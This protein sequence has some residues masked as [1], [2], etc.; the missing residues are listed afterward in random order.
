M[1][2][3]NHSLSKKIAK[4][5]STHLGASIE[6]KS[7]AVSFYSLFLSFL[8]GNFFFSSFI[9]LTLLKWWM[10]VHLAFSYWLSREWVDHVL[11]EN[12]SNVWIK[13]ARKWFHKKIVIFP[14]PV[15]KSTFKNW[16]SRCYIFCKICLFCKY[17]F[18]RD[19][20]NKFLI[21]D[22]IGCNR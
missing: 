13:D 2:W 19:I 10:V 15:W 1:F 8:V 11:W 18:V 12:W 7:V 14:S 17:I 9:F 16:I 22:N 20:K 3:I 4:F 6:W 5:S 21:K